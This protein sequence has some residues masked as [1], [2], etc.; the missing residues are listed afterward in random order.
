MG[1]S[2]ITAGIAVF[3]LV[4]AVGLSVY[5]AILAARGSFVDDPTKDQPTLRVIW[6]FALWS[7]K[8]GAALEITFAGIFGLIGAG[9]TDASNLI[10]SVRLLLGLVVV[11]VIGIIACWCLLVWLD[12]QE[13]LATLRWFGEFQSDAQAGSA[14]NWLFRALIGWFGL[15]AGTLLGV[16]LGIPNPLRGG[17]PDG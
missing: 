5:L 14:A 9:V 11:C 15:F 17:R 7:M 16:K 12:T 4:V 10:K 8:Q 1:K 2:K 6:V 3:A 13:T